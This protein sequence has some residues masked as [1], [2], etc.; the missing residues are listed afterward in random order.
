M[1]SWKPRAGV[2]DPQVT[3]DPAWRRPSLERLSSEQTSVP[4]PGARPE[5]LPH[6]IPPSEPPSVQGSAG[7]RRD[8]Q[9]ITPRTRSLPLQP[10]WTPRR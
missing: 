9:P 2:G 5:N 10:P 7:R 4:T 6:H 1:T 3:T 8:G